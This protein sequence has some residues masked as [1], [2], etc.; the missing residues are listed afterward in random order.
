MSV[1]GKLVYGWMTADA[2]VSGEVSTRVYPGVAPQGAAFPRITYTVIDDADR[3][4][5]KSTS[6]YS[7][8]V[9]QVDAWSRSYTGLCDLVEHLK[10]FDF[11]TGTIAS[12]RIQRVRRRGG[13]TFSEESPP[14]GS[15]VP[16]YRAMLT[17]HLTYED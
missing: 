16:I 12:T 7:V 3:S 17:Y 4:N 10:D 2:G 1:V 14:D 15:D 8:G 6:G 9:V 11:Y 5:L 13:P